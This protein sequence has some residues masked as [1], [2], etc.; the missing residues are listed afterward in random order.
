MA[1]T[2]VLDPVPELADPQ[3]P[4]GSGPDGAGEI[5]PPSP[6][7]V[8]ASR[9]PVGGFEG[10]DLSEPLLRAISELGWPTPTPIQALVIPAMRTGGE[11][12]GQ[13]QTGS[14][15]TAAFAIPIIQSI[16][17][18]QRH[19]QALV[20]VPTRELAEQVATDFEDL[21][22]FLEVRVVAIYGGTRYERQIRGLEEGAQVVV[23]TPGR[24]LDHLYR[25][26]L[27]FKNVH[28]VILD[29]ADRML[30]MGF[31]PDMERIL[32]QTPRTR[33]TALFSATIPP[34]IRRMVHRYMRNPSWITI[35]AP[36]PTVS[37]VKQIYYEVAERDKVDALCHLLDTHRYPMAL[38]FRHTQRGVDRLAAALKRRGYKAEAFHG[39][40]TQNERNAV[41]EAFATRK[42]PILIATNVASRGLDIEDISHVINFD[43]PE[44]FDT[45]VHRVGRTARAGKTGTAIT[46]VGEWELDA[47]DEYRKQLGSAIRCEQLP[48]YSS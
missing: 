42:V 24:I 36:E 7:V 46:F 21:C 16:D 1:I 41:L 6:A 29:E 40:M 30:D 12:V 45:Y 48:L 25:G 44:D 37:E 26:T 3:T 8:P 9:R 5:A 35:E 31:A 15:K 39:G 20:T 32:R 4:N 11:I 17:Q 18:A 14:G 28:T 19:V 2:P 13:S 10:L 23:G 27:S 38:I 43:I 47:F 34:Y 22:R 33:Q